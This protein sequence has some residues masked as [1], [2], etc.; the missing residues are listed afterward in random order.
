MSKKHGWTTRQSRAVNAPIDRLDRK[1]QYEGRD[2]STP[3][4]SCKKVKGIVA[5][6][7]MGVS[8]MEKYKQDMH[9]VDRVFGK[10][11]KRISIC[12]F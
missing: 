5:S 3:N 4:P 8:P 10:R 12:L 7:H 1:R 2:K 11:R 9:E 6:Y